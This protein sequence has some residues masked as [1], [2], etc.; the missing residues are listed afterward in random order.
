MAYGTFLG[1][2]LQGMLFNQTYRYFR[3]FLNDSLLLKSWVSIVF[4][5]ELFHTALTMH[6]SYYY[7]V[8][9]YDNPIVLARPTIWS[10]Q[11]ISIPACLTGFLSQLFFARRGW[12]VGPKWRATIAF[13]VLCICAAA[14]CFISITFLGFASTRPVETLKFSYIASI[15][16]GLALLSELLSTGVLIL[17]LHR[18]RTG[19]T[20]TDSV[21]EILIMYAIS[22][23][24][25]ICLCNILSM[26]FSI[27][28]PKNLMYAASGTVL[29]KVYANTFLVALNTRHT[30]V[31]RGI[32]GAGE[33]SPSH[34]NTILHRPNMCASTTAS[35]S[36]SLGASR[37]AI[38]VSRESTTIELK[39]V[40]VLGP[41]TADSATE[42]CPK[43][44]SDIIARRSSDDSLD[45]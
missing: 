10:I 44:T 30:L 45:V 5:L 24:F 39:A 43:A 27:V 2:M 38:T 34:H 42:V 14:G 33:T 29:V 28:W 36:R 6:S 41:P 31:A 1:L 8:T 40:S 23:G 21:F 19:I 3:T 22:T 37:M 7:L 15:G 4:L 26:T 25:I 35:G 16:S 13:S 32:L 12:L 11:V 18:S 17:V 9:N 20:R